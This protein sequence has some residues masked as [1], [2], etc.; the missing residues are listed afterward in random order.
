MCNGKTS[1]AGLEREYEIRLRLQKQQQ[2]HE[3][4]RELERQQR[5]NEG[6]LYGH[7]L[8]PLYNRR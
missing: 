8:P 7:G 5:Y 3:R 1:Q 2:E 6:L 4:L